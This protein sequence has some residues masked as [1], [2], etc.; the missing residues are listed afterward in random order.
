MP[1]SERLEYHCPDCLFLGVEI[2]LLSVVGKCVEIVH[3]PNIRGVRANNGPW[4]LPENRLKR[5]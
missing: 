5:E 1:H 2:R 3:E 4:V